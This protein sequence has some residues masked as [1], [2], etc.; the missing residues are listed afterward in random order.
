M[1]LYEQVNKLGKAV[2]QHYL[3]GKLEGV[4]VA[5]YELEHENVHGTHCVHIL[6]D[7]GNGEINLT[8]LAIVDYDLAREQFS[9]VVSK[10]QA[11]A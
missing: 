10:L 8:Q 5:L 4:A 7:T 2:S 1:S 9:D 3:A 6:H 11:A